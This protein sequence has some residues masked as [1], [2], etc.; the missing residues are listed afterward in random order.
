LFV[1]LTIFPVN[2][3]YRVL[4]FT[5]KHFY[6]LLMAVFHGQDQGVFPLAFIEYAL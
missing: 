2:L 4:Y 5:N 3:L 6:A 1:I